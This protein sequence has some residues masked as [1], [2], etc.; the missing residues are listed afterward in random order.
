MLTCV[1]QSLLTSIVFAPDAVRRLRLL[2]D[3]ANLDLRDLETALV[4][5]SLA[6]RRGFTRC[7]GG[8]GC[9]LLA[10]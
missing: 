6:H 8:D 1:G 7:P 10:P 4:R 5:L 2:A 3:D 9:V